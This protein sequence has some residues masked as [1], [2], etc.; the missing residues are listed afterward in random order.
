MS[1]YVD[2]DGVSRYADIVKRR[3]IHTPQRLGLAVREAR[4]EA[5]LTQVQLAQTAGVS[6][7]WLIALEAG[8]NER[9]ELGKVLS[10]IQTL[11]LTVQ[12]GPAETPATEA[13]AAALDYIAGL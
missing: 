10:T 8:A 1:A 13:E 11:H 4:R 3:D 2:I 12:L 7:A 5:G 6:R 9:A